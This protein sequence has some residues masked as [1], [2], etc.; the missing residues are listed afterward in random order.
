VERANRAVNVH[1]GG[2]AKVSEEQAMP[3]LLVRVAQ[4]AAEIQGVEEMSGRRRQ[5][6]APVLFLA[7]KI[8]LIMRR[9]F[10]FHTEQNQMLDAIAAAKKRHFAF[11]PT[12]RLITLTWHLGMEIVR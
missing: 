4:E 5:E 11:L 6:S 8:L 2:N 1:Q 3:V 10:Q 12:T 7:V 9:P